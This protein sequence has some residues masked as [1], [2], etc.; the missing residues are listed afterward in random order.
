MLPPTEAARSGET[1]IELLY[2]LGDGD[3]EVLEPPIDGRLR[4]PLKAD[5]S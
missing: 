1:P 2:D 5:K 4:L 3:L